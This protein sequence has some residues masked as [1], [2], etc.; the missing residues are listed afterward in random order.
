MLVAGS[1][2]SMT[3]LH[4]LGS[5]LRLESCIFDLVSAI[6]EKFLR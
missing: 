5:E 4:T 6:S 3:R 2:R 1:I